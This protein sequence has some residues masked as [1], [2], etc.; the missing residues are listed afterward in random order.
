MSNISTIRQNLLNTVSDVQ[1]ENILNNTAK[2]I[3]DDI[4]SMAPVDTGRY[5]DSMTIS[6]VN[7]EGSKHSIEIYSDLDSGWNGVALA[8]LLEWGTGIK[9]EQTNSYPHGYSYRQT[10]WVYYN[11]RYGRWIFTHGCVARPHWYPGLHNNEDYFKEQI[12]KGLNL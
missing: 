2:K 9:G 5:R 7:H 12:R 10:P 11:E 3:Y 8:Y 1:I 4:Y 6:N